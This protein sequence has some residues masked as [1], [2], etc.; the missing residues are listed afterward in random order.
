MR[1]KKIFMY[2]YIHIEIRTL[3]IA[4]RQKGSSR[5]G[6]LNFD[7]SFGKKARLFVGLFCK[8]G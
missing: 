5:I 3:G 7:I 2:I 6:S 4:G 1:D 8:T